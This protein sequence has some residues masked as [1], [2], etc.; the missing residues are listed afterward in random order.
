MNHAGTRE[1]SGPGLL[2]QALVLKGVGGLENLVLAEVPA[3]QVRAPHDVRVRLHAAALNRLD[4]F[5]TD[6]LPGV[7]YTFPHI[8]GSDGAGVVESVGAAVT[9]V[10]VGDRVLINPGLTC[11]TCAEC[12][13]GDD[14]LCAAFQV[15]GEHRSGTMA[16]YI[17]VP[18]QNLGLVPPQM[19][20]PEAAALSL[21]TLTAWR[22]LV[23]RARVQRDETVLVWGVGGGV[24]LAAVQ[25][26]VLAGARVIATSSSDAK[27][28]VARQYGAAEVINHATEDVVA[29]VRLLTA[30]RGA[31]V[32]VDSV[33]EPTWPRSLRL[34]RRGGRLV[35]CGAT[36]GP[37]VGID[38]RR[39]FWHQWSLLGSTLG[40]Q[41]EHAEIVR[42]AGEGKLWPHVDQVIPFDRA[43]E[44]F[45][46]LARGEQSGKVVIE[47][48]AG[49]SLA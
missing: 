8:V 10:K 46:R 4:L 47:M 45:G 14:P 37:Q 25:V 20:W 27:L 12:Q 17:V 36:G 19:P 31:E 33:G 32:I 9:R 48:P 39:L 44:A 29:R 23:T 41:A 49:A 43:L 24:A 26:A 3:P 38:I 6:G 30:N 1:T 28:E 40:S 2:M 15:L 11:G 22:M 35:T 21:A 7:A 16:E 13:R 18:E 42:L 34:L 5:V